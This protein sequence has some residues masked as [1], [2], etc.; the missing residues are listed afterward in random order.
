[1][2]RIASTKHAECKH[3]PH[4]LYS[5]EA[6]DG[7]ICVGCCECGSVLRGAM[8]AEELN[9]QIDS[10][11][12]VARALCPVCQDEDCIFALGESPQCVCG[13]RTQ[14]YVV[15]ETAFASLTYISDGSMDGPSS[16]KTETAQRSRHTAPGVR[17]CAKGPSH[18]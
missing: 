12:D 4:R 10:D 3:P 16:N 2:K 18:L 15:R 7:T 5:W 6:F 1:M 17:L 13:T 14:P 9:Q 8:S 11:P